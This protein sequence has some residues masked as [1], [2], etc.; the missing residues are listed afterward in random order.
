MNMADKTVYVIIFFNKHGYK[1]PYDK[2]K[3]HGLHKQGTCNKNS[4]ISNVEK[5]KYM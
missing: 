3:W 4:L 1:L 5:I 2:H